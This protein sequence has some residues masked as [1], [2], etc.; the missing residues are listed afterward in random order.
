METIIG[1]NTAKWKTFIAKGDGRMYQQKLVY[2]L[3]T[4]AV[5]F[6][7]YKV[8][9]DQHSSLVIAFAIGAA[10]PF[11]GLLA[12]ALMPKNDWEMERF[13]A[14]LGVAWL[15]ISCIFVGIAALA[16]L[17]VIQL[18]GSSVFG[19][20]AAVLAVIAAGTSG[21]FFWG[22]GFKISPSQNIVSTA[23]HWFVVWQGFCLFKSIC[24]P[25]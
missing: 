1:A 8:F 23:I 21:E 13:G 25:Y 3:L 18:A 11:M 24:G 9:G 22:D 16:G 5:F 17:V 4:L 7:I 2:V 15:F 12:I 6:A 19:V 14:G 20:M 10:A